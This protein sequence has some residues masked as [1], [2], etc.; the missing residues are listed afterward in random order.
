MRLRLGLMLALLVFATA[1][2]APVRAE[3]IDRVLAVVGG[4]LIT[5]SDVNAAYDLGLS[6]PPG[7][8]DRV[9]GVLSE[10]IDREVQLAEVN[11]YAPPDPSPADVDR[12]LDQVRMRFGSVAT[13]SAVLESAG[14]DVARLRERLRE[15]LRI[16]AYINQRFALPPD[17]RRQAVADWTASLRGRA[18]VVDLYL[19]GR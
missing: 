8:D 1:A 19:V 14:L 5:L 12:E 3:V 17:R 6:T 11:R 15:D 18:D 16:R 4:N 7:G 13:F 2:I 10:L 9:G